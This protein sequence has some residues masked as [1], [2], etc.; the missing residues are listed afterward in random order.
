[1]SNKTNMNSSF[2]KISG[3][4]KAAG[5]LMVGL[6]LAG[7]RG[8]ISEKPAI[9]PNMNMDQQDRKEAQE[10]NNFFEDKRSMR[11]PV[12]GTVARG[13]RKAD[14]AYYEGVNDKGEWIAEIPVDVDRSFLYRGQERYEIFC[15][16][17]HGKVGDGQGIIMTGQ[18]GYVPAPTFHQDRLREA[19]DGEIYS[20]IYNGVR[21]MPSYAHQVPVEDRW[22]IVSYI[23][24]LQASQ[25]VTEDEISTFDDDV[26][27]ESI[28][29]EF[30]AEQKKLAELEDAKNA[31][32]A[33]VI[34]SADLG[35]DIITQY[36]CGAC[37]NET[38]DLGGIGPTW[39]NLIGSEAEVLTSTGD[40]ITITKNEEYII[41]SI[42]NPE[43]KKTTGYEN[44]VMAAYDYLAD[45]E[46]QSIVE[47]IKTLSDN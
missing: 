23:R 32:N 43:A 30:T 46:L 28:K 16:P 31:A 2:M 22:A 25:Y 45:Y 34:P 21:N 33:D 11:P 18:Y 19:P 9:H 29:A 24:A 42:V 37:H 26:D 15:T 5:I 39:K 38:G 6:L 47:Y 1:M 35:K 41:E 14:M 20:A 44:G 4:H 3:L 7:C 40:R 8:T 27:L 13:Y 12:D 36:A 17:C 10:I